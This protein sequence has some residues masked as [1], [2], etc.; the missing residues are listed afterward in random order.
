MSRLFAL[1]L[2]LLVA[3]PA[4]ADYITPGL[5]STYDMDGLVSVSSGAVT[6][7][8]GAYQVHASVIISAGDALDIAPGDQVTFMGTGGSVGF[9]I[10]GKLRALGS[11]EAP[12]LLTGDAATPGCWRGLDYI[13]QGPTSE[14]HLTHVE[15]AFADNA[16]DVFGA[17]I[18]LEFCD[19]HDSLT[20]AVD[21]SQAG[22]LV[23]DCHIHHN[24]QRTI[25]MTLSSS[26]TIRDCIMDNNNL[27]N[28]SP[29]PYI[30]VGLQGTNSPTIEG[31]T[32]TGDG[33]E[34]SGGMAFWALGEAQVVNNSISGCGYG[35]LCYSTGA[36]PLIK[37]NTIFENTIHPDTVNWGFGVACN[38]NNAPTLVEND[39]RWH[40]YGVAAI[41]GGQP[42]LG[43]LDNADPT[44]DGGNFFLH[45][46]IG[47][48]TYAFFNNTPL[49]QMAQGN[50]WGTYT[51][52]DV[53][54]HQPDDASLGLVNFDYPL[55]IES[56]GDTP[57][58]GVLAQLKAYPNP[59]NPLV[60]IK[61]EMTRPTATH[62]VV[63]DAAGRV[64]RHLH[65]GLLPS[66]ETVLQWNGTDSQGR[67]ASSGVY[68][69][70]AVTA[71]SQ[72][73]VKASLVR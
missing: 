23:T 10:N 46:G 8:S 15:I 50:S 29:Y 71:E 41:N 73:T 40:W 49:A 1:V 72:R 64:V 52:E 12:I 43:N 31:C 3:L 39:I 34:M 62:V 70:R 7:G 37:G 5:G 26:P 63:M 55:I 66:G 20:K 33:N 32:I 42:N 19:I 45:N 2:C 27:E 28:S 9:E 21:F 69:L 65:D 30:N 16:V 6:G 54:W 4:L 18:T 58:A 44:D 35:I 47:G 67:A 57:A 13:D 61:L 14:F 22:G 56:A 38:G 17:D 51:P 11:A 59:F 24:Q 53:I 25:T 48:E 60:Q 68:W 36:N